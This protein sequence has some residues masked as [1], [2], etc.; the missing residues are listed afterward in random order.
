MIDNPS[1]TQSGHLRLPP[2]R[3]YV[4]IVSVR[5]SIVSLAAISWLLC[6]KRENKTKKKKFF[7]VII[8]KKKKLQPGCYSFWGST[9]FQSSSLAWRQ[10]R[11][12][13]SCPRD[14]A[15]QFL[16]TFGVASKK[17]VMLLCSSFSESRLRQRPSSRRKAAA[18]SL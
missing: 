10:Y 2:A 11:L 12:T 18:Y 7:V 15:M 6:K 4:H 3:T 8:K 13:R 14:F 17:S 5:E 1:I 9:I 16:P